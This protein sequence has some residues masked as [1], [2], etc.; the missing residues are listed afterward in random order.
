MAG[1]GG[2][3]DMATGVA[4]A[5]SQQR[6]TSSAVSFQVLAGVPIWI[7]DCF[8][9]AHG[10]ETYVCA[11]DL[12]GREC[13]GSPRIH[14]APPQESIMMTKSKLAALLVAV[15]M[16]ATG[17][18]N[19]HEVR[20]YVS[21]SGVEFIEAQIPSYVPSQLI[22]PPLTESFACVSATQKNTNVD[23][24]VLDLDLAMPG[25]DKIRVDITLA[26]NA[27][28]TL[29]I[30]GPYACL[31]SAVCSD[32]VDIDA[33]RAVLDF[34]VRIENGQPR[35]SLAAF[36]LQLDEDDIDVTL[37][38]CAIDGVVNTIVG[39]AKGW[40][41][42]FMETK[43]EEMAV[44]TIG[45]MLQDMV[46]GFLQYDLSVGGTN[47]SVAVND[48]IVEPNALT[49]GI[50][51][52]AQ[53]QIEA[54]DCV[55]G[56]PGEP[57]SVGDGGA[58][59]TAGMNAH[60]GLAVNFG[61]INDVLYHVWRQGM[62]CLSGDHLEALGLHL[63]YDHISALLPGFPSGT[64]LK[65]NL[66][67]DAPPSIR[68]LPSA[69]AKVSV[70][71]QGIEV[72]IVAT[73]PDGSER[74]LGIAIDANATGSVAIDPSTNSLLA[75]LEQSE[76]TRMD[77]DELAA[78]Q[79]G[80]DSAQIITMMNTQVMPSMLAKMGDL[81]VTGSMF[82]FAD[83]AIILRGL[84]TSSE[85]FLQ[86]EIDLFRAPANDVGAPNTTIVGS[87][88]GIVSP[89]D[90]KIRVGGTDQEIPSELL[91]YKV[92]VDGV[93]RPLSPMTLFS[94]GEVGVT[95]D[96]AIEVASVDLN[97][98]EDPTPATLQL[99]IDGIAPTVLVAGERTQLLDA[100]G[101]VNLAWTATDD[102]TSVERLLTSVKVYRLKDPTDP[103]TAELVEERTLRTGESNATVKV[104]SGAVYRVEV[105][106]TD[107][108][109]NT[110][111]SAMLLDVSGGCGC[112]AASSP[113]GAAPIIL[114]FMLASLVMR[115]RRRDLA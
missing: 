1:L 94:V 42:G 47:V 109:G 27:Q 63:D 115:K 17:T 75:R 102:L 61:L 36:D 91:R 57:E 98:N 50:D 44:T 13:A 71:L 51:I 90:A 18:A 4:G 114:A 12:R 110:A 77:L 74:I 38:D 56:D 20:G 85:S 65:L 14:L 58:T 84:E 31:G 97:G 89:L 19:A 39:F 101:P 8:M 41:L 59:F 15:P 2:L 78:A 64:E 26:A 105:N 68:G 73:L 45:P 3:P 46:V 48:F 7:D 107:E 54:S 67:L 100:A 103:V 29:D 6:G 88:S 80:F 83:Y 55:G 87:P 96:Y 23:L 99:T 76:I 95:R 28:G 10:L 53:S 62:T 40:I 108:A 9:E 86:A 5:S 66:K 104:G 22:A 112:R 25:T 92:T 21:A 37:S 43:V 81:P 11:R 93:E 106:V 34:D 52:D 79:L 72:E 60:L 32:E 69:D 35:I 113:T 33:V 49:V 111:T 70:D 30:D 16:L 24:Q 82:N